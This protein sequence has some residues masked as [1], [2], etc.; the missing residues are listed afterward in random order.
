MRIHRTPHETFFTTFGNELLRDEKISFTAL[1]ILVFLLS[2]PDGA[3]ENA[4]TLQTRRRE[5]KAAVSRA[6]AQLEE[7]GY[8]TRTL[9]RDSTTNTLRTRLAVHDHPTQHSLRPAVTAGN[10]ATTTQA[11]TNP[12]ATAPRPGQ[13]LT[14]SPRG[15]SS[16]QATV[17][18]ENQPATTPPPTPQN[19]GT[20]DASASAELL[21]EER[22]WEKKPSL[23]TSP[24]SEPEQAEPGGELHREGG[25][26]SPRQPQQPT[27]VDE[28]DQASTSAIALLARIAHAEPRLSLGEREAL[29]LAPLIIQWR[30]RGA[31]DPQIQ[32]AVTQ[33]LPQ[34][35]HSPLKILQVRLTQKLPPQRPAPP[36]PRP[37]HEC[38]ECHDPVPSPGRCR[39]CRDE[40]PRNSHTTA[41][42]SA[43]GHCD[44]SKAR[45]E[46]R[47]RARPSPPRKRP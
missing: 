28:R 42:R 4:E 8:F 25:R 12:P 37:R 29:Q 44:Y 1:G 31:T 19:P 35:I 10:P 21:S 40:T 14:G 26:T 23:P 39:T 38:A 41:V 3:R 13:P 33:G 7:R 6:L 22:T 2:L 11:P 46:I 30:R 15:A 27:P 32:E 24:T 9:V 36:A 34:A 18:G 47:H 5:G 45:S 16:P 17:Q 43:A 20:V